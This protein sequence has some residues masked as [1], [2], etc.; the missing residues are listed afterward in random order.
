MPLSVL[1]NLL[2]KPPYMST[3]VWNVRLYLRFKFKFDASCFISMIFLR[4]G[5]C[6][7]SELH[8]SHTMGGIGFIDRAVR[9]KRL[10]NMFVCLKEVLWIAKS[11]KP[12]RHILH[13]LL[14]SLPC[15]HHQIAFPSL[16]AFS[17][18]TANRSSSA[19]SSSSSP[20]SSL[21]L[22][23]LRSRLRLDATV[24]LC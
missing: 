20:R 11:C 4:E 2:T 7:L 8:T 14:Y 12:S 9:Y 5:L 18:M 3:R 10:A 1:T 15:K 23:R 22:K 19:S 21:L 13:S 16:A 6:A 24:F 17:F